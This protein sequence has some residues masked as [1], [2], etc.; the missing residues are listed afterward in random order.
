MEKTISSVEKMPK[1]RL[2]YCQNVVDL[3]I[4]LAICKI[5]LVFLVW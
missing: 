4:L 3:A 5:F 1:M 2:L